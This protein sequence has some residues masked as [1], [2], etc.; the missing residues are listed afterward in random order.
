MRLTRKRRRRYGYLEFIVMMVFCFMI[1]YSM[2]EILEVCPFILWGG[3]GILGAYSLLLFIAMAIL[4][5]QKKQEMEHKLKRLNKL[6]YTQEFDEEDLEDE[7][8]YAGDS[9]L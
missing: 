8:F 9:I 7:A 4:I 5:K 1:G 2:R 6:D 3:L